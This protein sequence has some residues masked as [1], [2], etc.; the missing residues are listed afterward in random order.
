MSF[1]TPASR[2][3]P[4][5]HARQAPQ[6]DPD[7]ELGLTE[8]LR[9]Q[10]DR[11]DLI[12]LLARFAAGEG[13]LDSLM[14]RAIWRA[15]ARRFGHG[16]RIGGGAGFKHLERFDIGDGVFIGAQAYLQGRFD[17]ECVIGDGVWI[18]PQCYLD[19]RDLII[20]DHAGWGPG[21]PVF[22]AAHNRLA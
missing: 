21:A 8:H 14:R 22:G 4:A 17:G 13:A 19:A 18:G 11:A 6:P 7:F 16:V 2:V 10:Y 1:E 9:A 20:G 12:E 3:V 5:V 15:L